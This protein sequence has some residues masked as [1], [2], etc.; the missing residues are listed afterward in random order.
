LSAPAFPA[1]RIRCA[2]SSASPSSA[3]QEGDDPLVEP[4][5]RDCPGGTRAMSRACSGCWSAAKENRERIAV[6]RDV[7]GS[8]AVAALVLQVVE[9]RRDHVPRSGSSPVQR[10]RG[11]LPPL[12]VDEVE[13]QGASCPGRRR[14]CGGLAWRLAGEPVG[15]RMPGGGWGPIPTSMERGRPFRMSSPRRAAARASSSGAA[16][17]VPVGCRPARG[18]PI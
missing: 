18:G 9:E 12:L 5:G 17:Q 11:G 3:V 8:G 6:R 4:L 15:E 16:G 2:A 7:A 1:S 10:P 13:Q 14:W